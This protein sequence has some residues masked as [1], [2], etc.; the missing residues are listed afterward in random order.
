[1]QKL[2]KILEKNNKIY[3]SKY[4]GWYSV[5]D[6]AYYSEEEIENLESGKKICRVTGSIVE[7]VE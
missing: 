2:W 4:S 1:M 5:S 7:W 3:L 6:E